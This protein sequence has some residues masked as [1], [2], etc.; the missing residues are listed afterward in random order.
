[1]KLSAPI[2]RLKRQARLLARE[3]KIPL[4]AALDRL[5]RQE[6]YRSWSHLAAATPDQSPARAILGSLVAGDLLL[7]G[8]R[9]GHGKTLLGLELAVAAARNGRRSFFF[10]L[11]DNE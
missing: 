8:A 1:M 9:P 6:G 2:F 5:A 10:S 7:L 4:H 11:E 3:A